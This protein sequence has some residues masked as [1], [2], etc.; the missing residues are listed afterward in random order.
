MNEEKGGVQRLFI[1]SFLCVT[2]E[3]F[4]FT[5]MYI[6]VYSVYGYTNY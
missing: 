3:Y 6:Q 1:F 4:F 2:F 5:I